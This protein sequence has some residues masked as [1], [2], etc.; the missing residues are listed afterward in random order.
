MDLK[1]NRNTNEKY[2]KTS[3]ICDK[4]VVTRITKVRMKP[5]S[6]QK[7]VSVTLQLFWT[8]TAPTAANHKTPVHVQIS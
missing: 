6:G 4:T 8:A 5:C 2:R 7:H 1:K 3:N